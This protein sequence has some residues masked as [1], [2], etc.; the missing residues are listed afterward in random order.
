VKSRIISLLLALTLSTALHADDDVSFL[1]VDGAG[2]WTILQQA[3]PITDKNRVTA[4]VEASSGKGPSGNAYVLTIHCFNTK[5]QLFIGWEHRMDAVQE[6]ITRIDKD[7]PKASEWGSGSRRIA[8]FHADP[9]QFIEEL[10]K[11]ER[12][13]A[14]VTPKGSGPL[15]AIFDIKG[16]DKVIAPLRKECGW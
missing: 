3:D 2:A 5:A 9:I 6:V 10:S 4:F 16:V 15:T 7:E 13:V 11:G 12:L 1:K 14:Q 8:L